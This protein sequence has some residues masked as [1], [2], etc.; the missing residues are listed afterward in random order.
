M[1][2]PKRQ[3]LIS[4]YAEDLDWVTQL[5]EK[6]RVGV[7]IKD[8]SL[9]SSQGNRERSFELWNLWRDSAPDLPVI[10]HAPFL[11]LVPGSPEPEVAELALKQHEEVMNLAEVLRAESVLFHSGFNP[12]IK[13]PQYQERWLASTSAYFNSLMKKHPTLK[14][15]IENMWEP[16]PLPLIALIDSINSSQFRL[17]LDVGHVQVYSR[18]APDSWIRQLGLR[19]GLVHLNDNQGLWDQELALGTGMVPLDHVF[20]AMNNL[21][22]FGRVTIEMHGNEPILRSM[23]YLM[24]N[25]LA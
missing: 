25:G 3:Y 4:A 2:L 7:E 20:Q 9:P 14:L 15:L 16:D 17:C 12:M 23:E 21:G 18:E 24:K 11:D 1:S 5:N 6:T 8:F 13:S 22:Y 19:L 10:V